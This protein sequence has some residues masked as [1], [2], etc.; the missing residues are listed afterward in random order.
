N[1]G[2]PLQTP[3]KALYSCLLTPLG[4]VIDDLIVYYFTEEFCRVV[5]NAG[6]AEK[7]IAWFNQLNEQGGFSL[8][9]APRRDFAIVAAQGP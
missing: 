5:V 1:N 4:G 8:T 9:I 6:T 3:G 2:A 7:D